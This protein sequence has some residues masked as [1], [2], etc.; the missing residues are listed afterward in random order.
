LFSITDTIANDILAVNDTNANPVFVVNSNSYVKIL[1]G[2]HTGETANAV[3][4]SVD[5]TVATGAVFDYTVVEN[6][7][8]RRTGTML[9][10]W[11]AT[12]NTVEYNETSTNDLGGSTTGLFFSIAITSNK[13]ELTANIASGTW[14]IKLSAR[15]LS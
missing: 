1:S 6:G 3:V 7:G 11:N 5:D 4:F 15:L 13:I 9:C 2:V 14:D 10:V 12:A 8:A